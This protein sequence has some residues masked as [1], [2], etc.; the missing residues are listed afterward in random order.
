MILS[1]KAGKIST[2][3]TLDITAKAKKMKADGI[4]VIGFG[5]GEPDFN[6]PKNIREAAIKA[7]NEGMTK[8]TAASGIIELKQA[9]IKKLKKDN[10][11]NYITDQI[12][13]STGAKQCLA[14]VFQAI[15]NPG[16][17]VIIGAPYWV[18]YPELVKLA[19]GVPVFVETEESNKF[20]LTIT[21][22]NRA[23]TSKSKAIILNS[24]NN[25]TGTV[26]SREELM[27]IAEFAKINNLIIIS[28]EIYEKLLYAAND[29]ISI[30]S[31][32]E[33]AYLRT[34]VINGLSKAYAMTGWRVGY[35]A[36]SK[37]IIALMSNIQSHTTSNP[38]SIA[39]YASVEALSGEQDD[40]HSMIEQFKIRRNYMVKRINSINNLSCIEPEG[41][42]YVMVNI[43]NI[44]NKLI[45]G[46][47]IKDSISFSKLLLE[48][49]KVAVIPGIAFGA[50]NFIRL[51]YATSMENIKQGLD[52][53][54]SFVS[55]I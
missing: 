32:S 25:P 6:T 28:D 52:R 2:S 48:K 13:V 41:A 50:E 42:F 16:D 29:H 5:A 3:L 30:A 47:V 31:L 45:D 18:S 26:Y 21:N 19:D 53:I 20:K 23:I 1:K 7:I 24:P 15:L 4:D 9:I 12:I 11:L 38:N 44:F 49:E 51:S 17:E 22:L 37:E 34:I 55:N 39:Q 14:N 43:S 54:E 27:N 10:S 36:G 33:D 35:A 8:Y 46:K 40:M